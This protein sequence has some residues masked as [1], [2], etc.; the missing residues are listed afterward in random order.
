[1]ISYEQS[2]WGSKSKSELTFEA[3][4]LVVFPNQIDSQQ[5][6]FHQVLNVLLR[7]AAQV[8]LRVLADKRLLA[9]EDHGEVKATVL[10]HLVV[11]LQVADVQVQT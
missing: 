2:L 11:E 5:A 3:G 4:N 8:D 10:K 7:A 9:D 6:V 1:M